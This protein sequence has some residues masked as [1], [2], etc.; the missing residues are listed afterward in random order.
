MKYLYGTADFKIT[1]G[2]DD[3]SNLLT[4]YVDADFAMDLGDRKSR[5]GFLLL[6][7]DGPVAWGSKKQSTTASSTTEAEYYAAHKGAREIRW[8]R[9]LLSDLGYPQTAPT[10]MYSDNQ[11]AIRLVHNPEFH[12]RTKHIDVKYHAI[13]EYC[14]RG[15]LTIIYVTTD[16]NLADVFTKPIA[17]DRF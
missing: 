16:N 12:Q 9:Q 17:R 7:N 14:Q 1:Y 10:M 6:L 8:M 15:D 13:C 2:G 3:R 4:A 5:S 11:A